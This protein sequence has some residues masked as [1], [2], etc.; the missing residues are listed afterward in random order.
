MVGFKRLPKTKE[1]RDFDQMMRHR[2]PSVWEDKGS[3]GEQAFRSLKGAAQHRTEQNAAMGASAPSGGMLP[4]LSS[5]Q[6]GGAQDAS[7]QRYR[8]CD[9]IDVFLIQLPVFVHCLQ[10]SHVSLILRL[11]L[12]H[13]VPAG[14]QLT[15]RLG[16]ADL[17]VSLYIPYITTH[18]YAHK[19]RHA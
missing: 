8:S 6:N 16:R 10:E 15:A 11:L 17:C 9:S 14:N 12:M 19:G 5:G 2:K 4:P 13:P 3:V 7:Q 18:V 1:E